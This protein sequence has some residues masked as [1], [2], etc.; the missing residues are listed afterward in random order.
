MTDKP[1]PAPVPQVTGIIRSDFTEPQMALYR[2]ISNHTA[3]HAIEAIRGVVAEHPSNKNKNQEAVQMDA[4]DMATFYYTPFAQALKIIFTVNEPL[5][6]G[7]LDERFVVAQKQLEGLL[8]QQW[9]TID[10]SHEPSMSLNR[11][12]YIAVGQEIFPRVYGAVMESLRQIA[13]TQ[14]VDT[15]SMH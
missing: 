1:A 3:L 10:P 2:E 13:K 12:T 8:E 5:R 11:Q 4:H 6:L 9:K 15:R 14:A 7:Q